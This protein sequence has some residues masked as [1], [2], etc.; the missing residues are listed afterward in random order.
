M[1]KRGLSEEENFSQNG[2]NLQT[3][4]KGAEREPKVKNGWIG[5]IKSPRCPEKLRLAMLDR[6]M[7]GPVESGAGRA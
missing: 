3:P 6:R 4:E 5:K 7:R 1:S 2:S